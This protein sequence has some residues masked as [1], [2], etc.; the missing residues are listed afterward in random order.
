MAVTMTHAQWLK[1]TNGGVM[2]IRSSELRKIDKALEAYEKFRYPP[3]LETLRSAIVGW[4]QKEGSKWKTSVRN[5]FHAV[6][7][8]YKQAFDLPGIPKT[9]ADM[10]AVSHLRDESRAIVTDLFRGKSLEWRPGILQKLMSTKFSVAKNL[11][12]VGV[13]VNDLT[14]G[15]VARGVASIPGAVGG[16]MGGGSGH[17][18]WFA[19]NLIPPE[20]FAEVMQVIMSELPTF[21]KDLAASLTP[22]VGVIASGGGALASACKTA[23]DQYRMHEAR[24]HKERSLAVDEPARAMEGLLRILERERDANGARTAI[25]TAEFTGKLAGVLADGGTAT[26]AAIGLAAS[27]ANLALLILEIVRDVQEKAAANKLMA[28]PL[29]VNSQLFAASPVTGAYLICCAPTSVLVN[30]VFDRFF[31]SGWKGDVERTVQ[32]HIAPLQEQARR[33]IHEHRF[34]IN[35][36]Q[37]FPGVLSV[38]K[39]KLDEMAARKGKTN[40]V[41]FG[42]D[43]MPA[44]LQPA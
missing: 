34:W 41:G 15:A 5:R 3:N 20:F 21:M 6:D 26:N 8:L 39:K 38:N 4:M 30:T 25:G 7:D 31:Q 27:A 18:S 17:A 1:L 2:S 9:A 14:G 24:V 23:R 19:Q 22:F 43:N 13:N 37:N 10:V 35:G 12:A 33:V 32:K 44:A 29:G 11:R 16:A 36:L 28:S 40:M 42:S